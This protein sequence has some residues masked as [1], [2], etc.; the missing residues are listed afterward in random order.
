MAEPTRDEL[1][2]AHAALIPFVAAYGLPLNPEELDEMAYAVVRHATSTATLDEIHEQV[3]RQIAEAHPSI[4]P[5]RPHVWIFHSENAQFASG[6]FADKTTALTWIERH[7]LT[8][9]LTEY[10]VGDGC[11]DIAVK[12]GAFRP[13]KPHHGLP[14]HVGGFSPSRTEHIHVNH[15]QPD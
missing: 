7:S 4:T 1:A 13:T 14:G 6:V 10:P 11:Y 3:R 12:D 8:G 5:H 9:I 15:G 2:R